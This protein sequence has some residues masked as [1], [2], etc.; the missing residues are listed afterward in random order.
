MK[1]ANDIVQRVE[2]QRA[3]S[4]D[5]GGLSF[6]SAD[7]RR[8]IFFGMLSRSNEAM[9][10]L[11][12]VNRTFYHMINDGNQEALETAIPL[13]KPIFST[14]PPVQSHEL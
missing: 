7:V 4:P 12:G 8:L 1:K 2:I 6:K 14:P 10:A 13:L 9:Q 5:F 3:S 11:K